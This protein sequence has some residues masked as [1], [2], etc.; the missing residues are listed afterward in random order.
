MDNNQE[1]LFMHNDQ[2]LKELYPFIDIVPDVLIEVFGKHK[3]VYMPIFNVNFVGDYQEVNHEITNFLLRY[4]YL[5]C[6]GEDSYGRQYIAISYH[7]WDSNKDVPKSFHNRSLIFFEQEEYY[8][9]TLND[10]TLYNKRKDFWG[11]SDKHIDVKELLDKG[12]TSGSYGPYG[13]TFTLGSNKNNLKNINDT[14]AFLYEIEL[15]WDYCCINIKNIVFGRRYT[16]F[17]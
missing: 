6:R 14:S 12:V 10:P 13:S 9:P 1:L 7:L 11:V 15:V 4:D 5:Y 2:E 17:V 16:I 8:N 3:I